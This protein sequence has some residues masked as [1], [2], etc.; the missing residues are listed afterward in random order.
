MAQ[1][2]CP[3][4]QNSCGDGSTGS[5][6]TRWFLS[7]V[8]VL[9][10]RG[11]LFFSPPLLSLIKVGFFFFFLFKTLYGVPHVLLHCQQGKV[12]WQTV[13][14]S[15]GP[16]TSLSLS[17]ES[18]EIHI[19]VSS[20]LRFVLQPVPDPFFRPKVVAAP[21]AAANAAGRSRVS[22]QGADA[23]ASLPLVVETGTA[24]RSAW[25][26][27]SP[28]RSGCVTFLCASRSCGCICGD[29]VRKGRCTQFESSP[30]HSACVIFLLFCFHVVMI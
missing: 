6:M 17:G 30:E 28:V 22:K 4:R 20:V 29:G 14:T 11:R 1:K 23:S 24:P 13:A 9:Y 8:C 5:I 7:D 10:C 21:R 12:R 25:V 19:A 2:K 3:H 18:R 16:S 26:W 27:C 15:R